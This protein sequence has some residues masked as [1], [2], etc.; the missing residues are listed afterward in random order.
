MPPEEKQRS[1]SQAGCLV[2]VAQGLL[3]GRI[4]AAVKVF[5]GIPYAHRKRP[6][7][8]RACGRRRALRMPRRSRRTRV[9][10]PAIPTPCLKSP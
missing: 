6:D 3:E 7:V 9:F 1:R 2:R 5:K 10:S 4:E 8:G